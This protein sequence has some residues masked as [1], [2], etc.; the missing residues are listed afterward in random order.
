MTDSLLT[1]TAIE[2]A[3]ASYQDPYLNTDLV[4]F[5]AVENIEVESGNVSI[6]I[7]LPYPSDFLK[8]G[9]AEILKL[10]VGKVEVV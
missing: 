10:M 7:R 6:N 9:K 3:L 8:G 5:G 2:T 1:Q 4:S